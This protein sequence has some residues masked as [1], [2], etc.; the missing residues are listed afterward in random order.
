MMVSSRISSG[1]KMLLQFGESRIL[2]VA[3][4]IHIFNIGKQGA[5]V[6]VEQFAIA[7]FG[8]AVDFCLAVAAGAE[9]RLMRAMRMAR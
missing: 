1:V 4:C 8:K 2:D 9:Q 7:P 3:A 6:G 5:F